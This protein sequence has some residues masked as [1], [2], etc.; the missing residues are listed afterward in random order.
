ME[1]KEILKLMIKYEQFSFRIMS[2]LT[3][4][5]NGQEVLIIASYIISSIMAF[6]MLL[7]YKT[8]GNVDDFLK[9]IQSAANA[10]TLTLIEADAENKP[11]E[12]VNSG[13]SHTTH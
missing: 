2:R 7:I 10:K 9:I 12:W 11:A 6:C 8:G 13:K 5:A 1:N 3:K 4:L